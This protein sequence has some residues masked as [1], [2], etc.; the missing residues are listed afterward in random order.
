MWV[1]VASAFVL[2][3]VA[4]LMAVPVAECRVYY[5]EFSVLCNNEVRIVFEPQFLNCNVVVAPVGDLRYSCTYTASELRFIPHDNGTYIIRVVGTDVYNESLTLVYV[6]QAYGK[7]QP[8][9]PPRFEFDTHVTTLKDRSVV[10]EYPPLGDLQVL[11]TPE[12]GATVRLKTDTKT[13]I[14]FSEVGNYNVSI[15]GM[16]ADNASYTVRAVV[17][18][19]SVVNVTVNLQTQRVV[20]YSIPEWQAFLYLGLGVIPLFAVLAF[21]YRRTVSLENA[22][23]GV[24]YEREGETE[25]G[26]GEGGS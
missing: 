24:L 17:S 19:V 13:E 12:E 21:V 15:S 7:V 18:V 26:V 5:H 1:F 4:L 16:T 22:L 25:G 10:F 6:V 9:P 20:T 8:P 3:L 23:R 14:L 2:L 11:V